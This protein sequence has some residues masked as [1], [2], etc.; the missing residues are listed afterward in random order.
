MAG[1]AYVSVRSYGEQ[2]TWRCDPCATGDTTPSQTYPAAKR[3]AGLHNLL[4]HAPAAIRHAAL[5]LET[6]LAGAFTAAELRAA[7]AA[8]HWWDQPTTTDRRTAA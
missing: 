7:L 3:E 1:Q 5:V 2:V 8:M 4:H 6:Q